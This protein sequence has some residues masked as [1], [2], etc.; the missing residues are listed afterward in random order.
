MMLFIVHAVVITVHLNDVTNLDGVEIS[1]LVYTTA[2]Y[3][4]VH[5]TVPVRLARI[6]VDERKKMVQTK[7]ALMRYMS[8]EVRSPLNV[9]HSGL[10]LLVEEMENLPYNEQRQ[11]LLETFKSIRHASGDLLQTM[12]DLLLLESMDS[13]AFS[14]EEE[15]T[16]CAHLTQIAENCGLMPREKGIVFAVD[17]QCDSNAS[18]TFVEHIADESGEEG[19][20]EVVDERG[21][22]LEF[23]VTPNG[24]GGGGGPASELLLFID[25][26]K[27]GQVL[28]NLI[29][30]SSKFTPAGK[31]IIVNIRPATSADLTGATSDSE[32]E[33]SL[34]RRTRAL[35]FAREK[36]FIPCGHVVIEVEDT[37]VGIAPE[38]WGKVFG[39]FAQFDANKLQGGGGSGLGLWICQQFFFT[40]PSF[41]KGA[42][43]AGISAQPAQSSSFDLT[44]RGVPIS[45]EATSSTSEVAA[46]EA[47][48]DKFSK[49]APRPLG[50]AGVCKVLLVDDSSFNVKVMKNI[51][52]K[53]SAAWRCP[54]PMPIIAEESTTV[55]SEGG[56][57]M[58]AGGNRSSVYMLTTSSSTTTP[59]A[60]STTPIFDYEDSTVNVALDISEADDGAVA[61]SLVTA[62]SD[63]GSPFDIVFMD[64]I[65]IL[66]HGPEAARAMRAEGFQGFIVGVTGN[67]MKDD[68]N[69]Y[70]ISGADSVLGK[71]VNIEEIK[72]I[73]SR[74]TH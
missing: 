46:P 47:A 21:K 15:M 56:K 24:A 64:N 14:I 72:K 20:E 2:L 12:N 32:N 22:D 70:I 30:N 73:L 4:V 9:I 1:I 69:E 25:E 68:V 57:G 62:A 36:G 60:G 42:A 61:V 38:N 58:V 39:Q 13:A 28:R 27:I 52:K 63:A 19:R 10:N 51:L 3:S 41:K 48:A 55:R 33:E 59:S 65:M 17:N 26:H 45:P 40:L 16:P 6:A 66:M 74:F 23:G 35:T 8:H 37:G 54:S 43:P 53:V 7:T 67:L 34:V 50:R 18:L 11:E 49:L 71:P 31:S 5:S 29:T 44:S